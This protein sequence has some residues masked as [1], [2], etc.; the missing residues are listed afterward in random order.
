M[1]PSFQTPTEGEKFLRLCLQIPF[2]THPRLE[3]SRLIVSCC[4]GGRVVQIL[5]SPKFIIQKSV[6]QTFG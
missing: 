5:V 4:V 1:F 6:Q 2:P 3:D